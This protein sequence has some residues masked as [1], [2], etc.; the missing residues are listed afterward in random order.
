MLFVSNMISLWKLLSSKRTAYGGFA[1]MTTIA[2]FLV[3]FISKI[4]IYISRN[5]KKVK[6]VKVNTWNKCH[7]Y[8]KLCNKTKWLRWIYFPLQTLRSPDQERLD[9][10]RWHRSLVRQESWI[11]HEKAI[12]WQMENEG[13]LQGN[14]NIGYFCAEGVIGSIYRLSCIRY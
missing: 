3:L 14:E 12:E 1:S 9:N 13:N 5:P 8:W 11:E 10:R 2:N 6:W 7:N 4:Y